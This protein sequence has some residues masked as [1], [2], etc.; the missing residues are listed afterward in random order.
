MLPGISGS[1]YLITGSASFPQL[2]KAER[3]YRGLESWGRFCAW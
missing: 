3:I 1:L 2:C